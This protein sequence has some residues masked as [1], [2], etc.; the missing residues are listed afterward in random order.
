[1]KKANRQLYF[2]K[3]G[4]LTQEEFELLFNIPTDINEPN[5]RKALKPISDYSIFDINV[6]KYN[7][8]E[9]E[10]TTA[11]LL[12]MISIKKLQIPENHLIALFGESGCGKSHLI[13]LISK[14]KEAEINTEKEDIK[15]LKEMADSI[16][17]I[18]KKT[19]RPSRDGEPNKPEIQ[20]GMSLEEVE[21]CDYTYT[22][23][24]NLYGMLKQDIDKALETGDAIVIANDPDLEIMRKLKKAYPKNLLP[25]LVYR[26]IDKEEWANMMKKDGRSEEEIKK[27]IEK[28]GFTQKIYNELWGIEMPDVIWNWPEQMKTNEILLKQ[29]KMAMKRKEKRREEIGDRGI[30]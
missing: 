16:T 25:I 4:E 15:E 7:K 17:I 8:D 2:K 14:L 20:E 6:E 30:E 12:G 24:G 18:Q 28:F 21:K 29:L 23:S 5:F 3:I 11:Y 26:T 19:T 1:M 13:H 27:R 10:F 22:M 9:L